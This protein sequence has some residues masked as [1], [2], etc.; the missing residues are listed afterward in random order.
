MLYKITNKFCIKKG[1]KTCDSAILT[2]PYCFGTLSN[3]LL[4]FLLNIYECKRFYKNFSEGLPIL[5][6]L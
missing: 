4:L 3:C 1:T 5:Q 6:S 2:S